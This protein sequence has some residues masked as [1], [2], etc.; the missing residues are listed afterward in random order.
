MSNQDV[1][2]IGDNLVIGA[3]CSGH[4]LIQNMYGMY[5]RYTESS[6]DPDN[7]NMNIAIHADVYGWN[8]LHGTSL[9]YGMVPD[10]HTLWAVTSGLEMG[11]LMPSNIIRLK[12]DYKDVLTHVWRHK[13]PLISFDEFLDSELGLQLIEQFEMAAAEVEFG[14]TVHYEDLVANP[15]EVMS[16]IIYQLMPRWSNGDADKLLDIA[17][18]DTVIQNSQIRELR[19]AS[20]SSFLEKVEVYSEWISPEQAQR[21]DEFVASL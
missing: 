15:Q 12:R 16:K 14:T 2:I 10:T 6:G 17:A 18:L 1:K 13:L 7:S 21:I 5:L 11:Q 3:Y 8:R 20:G 19:K 9:S 4:D